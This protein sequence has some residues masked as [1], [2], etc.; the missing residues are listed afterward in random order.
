MSFTTIPTSHTKCR[1]NQIKSRNH[2]K[3]HIFQYKKSNMKHPVITVVVK[4]R[5][6][7]NYG[8]I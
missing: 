5:K 3:T 7:L 8:Q 2:D 4:R 1:R 6:E